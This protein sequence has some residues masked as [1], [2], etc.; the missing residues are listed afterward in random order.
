MSVCGEHQIQVQ[1]RLCQC[2]Y[3]VSWCYVFV[4]DNK[5]T[6]DRS[7][8]RW[9]IRQAYNLESYLT[10]TL[11]FN[12]TVWPQNQKTSTKQLGTGL[13]WK[14]HMTIMLSRILWKQITRSN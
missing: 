3:V 8:L 11:Q 6:G 9:F 10:I 13:V 7:N 12:P 4:N 2:A 5:K 14:D 1:K